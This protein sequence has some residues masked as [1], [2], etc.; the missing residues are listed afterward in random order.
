MESQNYIDTVQLCKH[1]SNDEHKLKPI[2]RQTK[3]ILQWHCT[4][5]CII[6]GTQ[7]V[8]FHYTLLLFNSSICFEYLFSF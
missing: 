7:D 1:K 4:L 2:D 6:N 8:F 3:T 5:A